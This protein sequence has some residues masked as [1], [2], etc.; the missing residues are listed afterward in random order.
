MCLC[1]GASLPMTCLAVW[2]SMSVEIAFYRAKPI[3]ILLVN[4]GGKH[5]METAGLILQRHGY[6]HGYTHQG[7]YSSSLLVT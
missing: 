5:T 3:C 1:S 4:E 2:A 7:I 6:N